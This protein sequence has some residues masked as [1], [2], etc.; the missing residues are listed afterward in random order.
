MNDV[1][2]RKRAKRA[3][4]NAQKLSDVRKRGHAHVQNWGLK[5]PA[6]GNRERERRARQIARGQLRE[7]NGLEQR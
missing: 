2:D 6:T 3:V 7:E 4:D 1:R 5:R